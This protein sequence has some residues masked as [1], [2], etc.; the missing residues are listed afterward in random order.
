[1]TDPSFAQ[2]VVRSSSDHDRHALGTIPRREARR[3]GSSSSVS[4]VSNIRSIHQFI[5]QLAS[6]RQT[7]TTDH[8]DRP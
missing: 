6:V 1:M 7:M 4:P 3:D 8:D 2:F 5:N